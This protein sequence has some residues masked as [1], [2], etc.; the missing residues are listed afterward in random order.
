MLKPQGTDR[1]LRIV[2]GVGVE[3]GEDS[4]GNP[5]GELE[6]DPMLIHFCKPALEDELN[7]RMVQL[8]STVC[9][10]IR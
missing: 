1:L 6:E 9:D 10:H 8:P 7:D 5:I 4:V 3:P 2:C